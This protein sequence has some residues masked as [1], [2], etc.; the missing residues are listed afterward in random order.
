MV[1]LEGMQNGVVP[2]VTNSFS[3][4]RAII[5]NGESGIIVKNNDI[6]LY[7]EKIH[8]IMTNNMERERLAIGAIEK[9]REFDIKEI[10]NQWESLFKSLK[11]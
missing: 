5:D 10:T 2:I 7:A 6:N 3:A 4:A 11:K 1:I 9:S 8:S